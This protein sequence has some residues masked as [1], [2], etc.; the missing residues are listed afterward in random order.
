M[1]R[2]SHSSEDQGFLT[3]LQDSLF[4][5]SVSGNST[6]SFKSFSAKQMNLLIKFW[7]INSIY[8]YEMQGIQDLSVIT[9]L[10]EETC[11]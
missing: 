3:R 5:S 1:C 9:S 7:S 10:V 8:S 2:L 11:S 4:T 6:T